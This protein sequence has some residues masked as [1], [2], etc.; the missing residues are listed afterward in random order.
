[1]PLFNWSITF[2]GEGVEAPNEDAVRKTLSNQASLSANV[3]GS[4]KN[5][6]IEVEQTSGIVTAPAGAMPDLRKH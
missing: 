2:T 4:L 5:I 1:M 6:R 3:V